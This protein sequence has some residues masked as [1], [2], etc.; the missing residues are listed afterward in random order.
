[1]IFG[2]ENLCQSYE[3]YDDIIDPGLT[4][5]GKKEE[6]CLKGLKCLNKELLIAVANKLELL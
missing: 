6:K 2:S 5:K 4:C 1:M 3:I